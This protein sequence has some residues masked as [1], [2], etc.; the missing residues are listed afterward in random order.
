MN[1]C[2]AAPSFISTV[3]PFMQ[4]LKF[5]ELSI[6]LKSLPKHLLDAS[7]FS[8]IAWI[9]SRAFVYDALLK[10]AMWTFKFFKHSCYSCCFS[11]FL[12]FG[13]VKELRGWICKKV[14]FNFNTQNFNFLFELF[15]KTK[16][17]FTFSVSSLIRS[18]IFLANT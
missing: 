7:Y 4:A 16:Q 5:K 18:C 6:H 2:S 9:V 13:F 10:H 8:V 15:W 12:I 11:S 14:L 3:L 1:T 17:L